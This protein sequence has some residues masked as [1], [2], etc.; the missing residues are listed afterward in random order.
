MSKNPYGHLFNASSKRLAE[1][2]AQKAKP[3]AAKPMPSAKQ[4]RR[5][6]HLRAA[7]IP[8]STQAAP[9]APADTAAGLAEKMLSTSRRARGR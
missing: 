7:V 8:A 2:K 4:A 5:F 1:L 9:E 6:E 3:V